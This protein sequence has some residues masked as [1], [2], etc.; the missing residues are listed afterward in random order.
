MEK[1]LK[2]AFKQGQLVDLDQI[3]FKT[4]NEATLT[5][6]EA[7]KKATEDYGEPAMLVQYK[8]LT[9]QSTSSQIRLVSMKEFGITENHPQYRGK[10]G[11]TCFCAVCSPRVA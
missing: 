4:V 6:S 8:G 3:D 7:I 1:E 2:K 5:R 10:I 11:N 9:K